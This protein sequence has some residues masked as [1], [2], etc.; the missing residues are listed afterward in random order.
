MTSISSIQRRR[1]YEEVIRSLY[2]SGEKPTLNEILTQVSKYFAQYPAGAP[3]KG[4]TSI[5]SD[6]TTDVNRLNEAFLSLQHNSSVAYE[7]AV[8]QLRDIMMLT[9]LFQSEIERLKA[10]RN[11]LN[12]RLDDYL[13]SLFNTD[14]YFYSVSDSFA[15]LDRVD[16][17]MT[18]GVVDTSLFRVNIPARGDLSRPVPI[19]RINTS[20]QVSILVDGKPDRYKLLSPFANAFDGLDNTIWAIEVETTSPVEVIACVSFGVG[21]VD[22]P[23]F[24]SSVEFDPWGISPVQAMVRTQEPNRVLLEGTQSS[25]QSRIVEI[26]DDI[27]QD[28]MTLIGFT[29]SDFDNRIRTSSNRIVFNDQLR[30]V[31][32]LKF[33]LR[34]ITPDYTVV[35]NGNNTVYRYIFGA[36]DILLSEQVYDQEATFVSKGLTLPP[37]VVGS[38]HVIDAVSLTVDEMVPSGTSVQ[39]YVASDVEGGSSIGDFDWK[40]ITPANSINKAADSIVRFDGALTTMRSI[41]SS[42]AGASDLQLIPAR[43]TTQGNPAPSELNPTSDII[44]GTDIWR[45]A[46]L[47][48]DVIPSSLILEEGINTT[49]VLHTP[50]SEDSLDL[51][52]W[53]DYVN[54]TKTASSDLIRIDEGNAFFDGSA[55]GEDYRSVYVETFVESSSA[56]DVILKK[57]SKIGGEARAWAIKVFLNGRE[58][59]SMGLGVNDLVIPWRFVEGL[60]HVILLVQIPYSTGDFPYIYNGKIS[61]ME[62]SD[63]QDFGTVK[64][65]TWKYVDFFQ[66]QYNETGDPFTFTIKEVRPGIKEIISRRKPTDNFRLRYATALSTAPSGIRFRADLARSTDNP[67]VTPSLNNYR[68]KFLYA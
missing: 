48:D 11:V 40:P 51:D 44:V 22:T 14:G 13:F 3:L 31:S 47:D 2:A 25:G 32:Q 37:E 28:D 45:L 17:T 38:D 7:A 56:T 53:V 59:A 21:Q 61:L 9:S 62:D 33:F 68:I 55:I 1:L 27:N 16:L 52:Y 60:N 8:S 4:A 64:L 18:S 65:A 58:I 34:K 24:L 23:I 50:Y 46:R 29:G 12:A 19:N 39:Y 43:S 26:P 67:N 54:G 36:K 5:L 66:M 30:R 35:T 10:R 49:R 6:R 20:P 42:P 63:L 41:V 57:I 15:T